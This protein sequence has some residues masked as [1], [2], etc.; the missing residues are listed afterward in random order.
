MDL[1]RWTKLQMSSPSTCLTDLDHKILRDYGKTF[2]K[3]RM[4]VGVGIGT[5]PSFRT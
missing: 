1:H 5:P 2:G 3:V 4:V